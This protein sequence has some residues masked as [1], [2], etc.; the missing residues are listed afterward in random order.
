[1]NSLATK[2]SGIHAGF[3]KLSPH[4][5]AELVEANAFASNLR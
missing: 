1:M 4:P 3:G 5:L 2:A